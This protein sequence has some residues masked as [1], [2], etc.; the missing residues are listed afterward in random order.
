M[1]SSRRTGTNESK[2]STPGGAGTWSAG[3]NTFGSAGNGRDYTALSLWESDT[4]VD[5]VTSTVSPVLECYRDA[6]SYSIGSGLSLSGATANTTYFRILRAASGARHLGVSGAGIVLTGTQGVQ[7]PDTGTVVQDIEIV[8]SGNAAGDVYAFQIGTNSMQG[9]G[10]LLKATNA[11]AGGGYGANCTLNRNGSVLVNCIAYECKTDGFNINAG[12][13]TPLR[14]LNCTSV[15]NGRY[16]FS[17]AT[18]QPVYINC[19]GQNNGTADWNGAG[20]T[21]SDYNLS[22]DTTAPGAHK[23]ISTTLTFSNAAADDY[24]LAITDTAAIGAGADLSADTWA[25]DD[26]IAFTVR[27]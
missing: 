25:F 3:V 27:S 10:L 17:Y 7:S 11:G 26:D 4:D 14:M 1:A 15:G 2:W 16:G 22:K 20:G 21:G 9:V 19:I 24:R 23:V 13:T 5:I 12:A 8:V 6:A 18:A